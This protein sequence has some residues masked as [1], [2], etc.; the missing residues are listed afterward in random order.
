MIEHEGKNL[1]SLGEAAHLAGVSEKALRYYDEHGI[2]TPTWKDPSS[3][4]RFYDIET[5]YFMETRAIAKE[6]SLPVKEYNSILISAEDIATS[7]Y[8]RVL[9][10]INGIIEEKRGRI[11]EL[12]DEMNVLAGIQRDIVTIASHDLNG[13]LFTAHF[14]AQS[15]MLSFDNRYESREASEVEFYKLFEYLEP[16][17]TKHV[18]RIWHARDIV[19]RNLS[20]NGYLIELKPGPGA[21]LPADAHP[22]VGLFTIP[23]GSYACFLINRVYNPDSW[24]HLSAYLQ[25]LGNAGEYPLVIAHEFG[26]YDSY[27]A[28]RDIIHLV[29]IVPEESILPYC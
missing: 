27:E 28:F 13:E 3:G 18:G 24:A 4:Y 15:L 22:E 16:W 10:N 29:R 7:N 20:A 23:D 14:D 6:L 8:T 25:T 9:D 19:E 2:V 12:F 17:R 21:R 26:Y 11:A 5:I 1:F